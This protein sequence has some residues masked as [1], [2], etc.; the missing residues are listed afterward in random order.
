MSEREKNSFFACEISRTL[1][2]FY[3]SSWSYMCAA[4]RSVLTKKNLCI[5][6][7][8]WL[9]LF[10][11]A[12]RKKNYI[13]VYAARG[14]IRFQFIIMSINNIN[15]SDATII[16]S[17]AVDVCLSTSFSRACHNSLLP[18]IHFIYFYVDRASPHCHYN[19]S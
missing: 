19:I 2:F 10:K 18:A 5:I 15:H 6:F 4:L 12:K 8:Y 17:W 3:I 11:Q 14:T 1:R 7:I 13:S 16:L 9:R